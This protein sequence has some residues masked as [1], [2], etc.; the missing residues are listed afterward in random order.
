MGKFLGA[1]VVIPSINRL[2]KIRPYE[3]MARSGAAGD[4]SWIVFLGSGF[5]LRPGYNQGRP[6]LR[7]SILSFI[8]GT[9]GLV[10]RSSKHVWV[11]SGS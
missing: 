3:N 8:P 9:D 10:M 4:K 1:L 5:I 7:F 2:R 11:Q 6:T